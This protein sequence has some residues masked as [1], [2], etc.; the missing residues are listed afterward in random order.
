[1]SGSHQIILGGKTRGYPNVD[2]YVTG[3]DTDLGLTI[4]VSKPSGVVSGDRL[5][6]V[7]VGNSGTNDIA[8]A[9]GFTERFDTGFTSNLRMHIAD[10]T[11][12]G[13]EGSTFSFTGT[14][15]LNSFAYWCGRIGRVASGSTLVIDG[16]AATTANPDPPSISPSWGTTKG[17]LVFTFLA[18]RSSVT[19]NSWPTGGWNDHHS[20]QQT[21]STIAGAF[22]AKQAIG[23]SFNPG[24]FSMSG[25][26]VTISVTAAYEGV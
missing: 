12:D 17:S 22:G 1:M 23:S 20:S 9:T 8:A 13:T 3:T 7:I 4:T 21:A 19:L 2:S 26:D 25:S 6:V 15:I 16:V 5:L 24:T 18:H 10:R 14:E 11:A